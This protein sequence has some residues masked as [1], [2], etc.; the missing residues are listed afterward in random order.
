MFTE[1]LIVPGIHTGLPAPMERPITSIVTHGFSAEPRC[2]ADTAPIAL[3]PDAPASRLAWVAGGGGI[4]DY[5]I[6]IHSDRMSDSRLRV[7]EILRAAIFSSRLGIYPTGLS[8][9]ASRV[10]GGLLAALAPHVPEPGRLFAVLPRL[11]RELTAFAWVDSVARLETPS[12]TKSQI[13]ASLLPGTAFGVSVSPDQE[14]V[15]LSSD[16]RL[17]ELPELDGDREVVVAN[18]TANPSWVAESVEPAFGGLEVRDEEEPEGDPSKW[19]GTRQV[20]EVVAYP[21]DVRALADRLSR[22]LR[23]S[24]C[25]W[26]G[27]PMAAKLCPFCRQRRVRRRRPAPAVAA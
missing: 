8:P 19:W 12:P 15:R 24:P 11:E 3:P 26:C 5:A 4:G 17:P 27:E 9:L 6:A 14:I 16:R 20:V 22:G 23:A 21:T 10:F 13:A 7:L 25:R 2:F 18:R 1:G